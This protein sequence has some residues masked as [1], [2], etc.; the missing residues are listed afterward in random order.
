MPI[1]PNWFQTGGALQGLVAAS[2]IR[3]REVAAELAPGASVGIYRVIRELGR[4][5]MAIVYLARRAD[6]EYEQQVALKWMLQA[7]PDAASEALFR[8]ERQALADLRH[9]HIARLLD[10]GR[11]AEGRPWFAMECIEG[12]R[13][14]R[15]CV[16]ADLAQSQRLLLFQQVCAAVAFA[17]ARGVIHRDIKPSNV[18]VDADGSAKLLD[19]GIA[20]LLGQDDALAARAFTPGFASPEQVRG[21]SLTVASDVYQLG[22]LL[23][24]VLSAD[25]QEQATLTSAPTLSSHLGADPRAES[26]LPARLHPDLQAILRKAC[27]AEPAQRYSTVAGLAEDVGA[28]M[29]HRPV[30]A[31]PHSAGY[32]AARFVRRYPRAVFAALAV[33]TL[34]AALVAGFALRLRSERDLATYQ[35]GVASSVLGFLR[36]DLLASAD[37]AALPGHELTVRDALDRASAAAD[38]R[39]RSTPAEHGLI[40][41]TLSSLYDAL[42]RYDDAEREARRAIELT[43]GDAVHVDARHDAAFALVDA[44]M[45]RGL[46]DQALRE[47]DTLAADLGRTPAPDARATL[48]VQH[49]RAMLQQRQGEYAQGLATAQEMRRAA[50][51]HLGEEDP[52][53][54]AADDEMADNLLMLGRHDE[55]LAIKQRLLERRRRELGAR[56]PSTLLLAHTVGVLKRHQGHADEAVALLAQV[57]ADRRV[58]L[59]P[60][61]P[62]TLSSMNELATA[63]QELHRY[64]EA[65]PLFRDVLQARLDLLGEEHQFTR[66]SMSNL[67]LLYSLWG[68]LDQA[69]PLYGRALAVEERLIGTSHPDTLALM[70][71]IAGLYRKQ[72]LLPEALAMHRRVITAAEGSS[73]LGPQAWQTALFRAGMALT[74]QASGDL[75]AAAAQLDQSIATLAT[76]LGPDHPRTLRAREM[77]EALVVPTP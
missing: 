64:D 18:L 55:A 3:Q 66:N 58:V 12:Q 20:Q 31:R 59:G 65:E 43:P 67:G 56:H 50:V 57:L 10:G 77:R 16:Q 5:G 17:H 34:T 27:A 72:A 47:L 41:T 61:H 15:H 70:H 71:N 2:L 9:P 68:R 28:F 75:V 39:F 25:A 49:R 63:L 74:L 52:V 32:V 35:A 1:D 48:W 33:V 76:S 21:E 13:L 7:R 4:G 22:R 38:R 53:V 69:A 54:A 6:G 11:T 37:P 29:E 51:L 73:E 36:E 24:S 45:S 60:R 44:L 19:F 26:I 23:A 46:W 8:R 62:E 42:G 30:A 14:D 40:R